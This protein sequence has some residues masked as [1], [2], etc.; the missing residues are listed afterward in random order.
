MC[1]RLMDYKFNS[2]ICLKLMKMLRNI[3]I[4]VPERLE[5]QEFQNKSYDESF[6]DDILDESRRADQDQYDRDMVYKLVY[7]K[8]AP[9]DDKD[10]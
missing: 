3:I 1:L 5:H 8:Y 4:V 9:F 7:K 6:D 2:L 10:K